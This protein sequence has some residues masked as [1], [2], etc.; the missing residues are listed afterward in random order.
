MERLHFGRRARRRV[1]WRRIV[2]GA[3]IASLAPTAVGAPTGMGFLGRLAEPDLGAPGVQTSDSA[4]ALLRFR[5]GLFA[6]RPTPPEPKPAERRRA[7]SDREGPSS[8]T[9]APQPTSVTGIVR[10][11]AA[12]YGL[13]GDYLVGVAA[14]ESDLDPNASSDSGY[15][16]LFQFDAQTWTAYGYGSIYD[17]VAQART[18]ARLLSEGHTSRWPN[19]A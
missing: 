16:G 11:A 3:W 17:P 9:P 2:I 4:A 7:R 1:R 18:A 14:C 8:A 15:Y 13:A 19:C 10:A 5:R 6:A 12:E